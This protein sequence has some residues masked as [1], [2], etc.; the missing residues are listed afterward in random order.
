M[1]CTIS[2]FL[3][4]RREL[5]NSLYPV[6]LRVYSNELRKAKLYKTKFDYTEKEFAS[7]WQTEKPRKVYQT[8]RMELEAALNN[9]REKGKGI[10]PFSFE[11]FE[12]KLYLKAGEGENVF[13]NISK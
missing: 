5:K 12:K 1:N 2:I 6:K 11:R 8:D 13:T 9:A 3:D 7:I 4:T 10:K